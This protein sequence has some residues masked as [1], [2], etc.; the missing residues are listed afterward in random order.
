MGFSGERDRSDWRPRFARELDGERAGR[1]R[2][3]TTTLIRSENGSGRRL[4]AAVAASQRRFL[5]A[6]A[7]KGAETRRG[8][9]GRRRR[10]AA[11]SA[12]FLSVR[13]VGEWIVGGA[14]AASAVFNREREEIGRAVLGKEMNLTSGPHPSAAREKEGEGR[15][16]RLGRGLGRGAGFGPKWPKRRKGERERFFP[17]YF[18][19]NFQTLFQMNF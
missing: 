8:E 5:S 15:G 17:F 13:G 18:P 7:R 12:H 11:L 2:K 1:E 9:L 3:L 19:T 4:R 14:G 10:R 16:S 6:P